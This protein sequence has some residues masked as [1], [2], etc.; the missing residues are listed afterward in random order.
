MV[1]WPLQPLQPFQKTQLQPPVGPS[2]D[3][4]CHLWLTTTNLSYY[5][6]PIFETSAAALCGTTGISTRGW[7]CHLTT[8]QGHTLIVVGAS[9]KE[10]LTVI[11]ADVLILLQTSSKSTLD[12]LKPWTVQLEVT[13][14]I[15]GP[16][17]MVCLMYFS[18]QKRHFFRINWGQYVG[19]LGSKR[20]RGPDRSPTSAEVPCACFWDEVL[21]VIQYVYSPTYLIIYIKHYKIILC[22]IYFRIK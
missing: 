1:R 5:S 9:K 18:T 14:C 12:E 15:F 19:H 13:N 7:V 21:C 22:V 8:G 2:V 16:F 17:Y 4:L 6:F 3:S 11:S 10:H 20:L